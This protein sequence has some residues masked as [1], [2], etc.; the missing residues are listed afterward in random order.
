MNK[1]ECIEEIRKII[2]LHGTTTI[3]SKK[4]LFENGYDKLY[5][6][7][8]NIKNLKFKIITDTIGLNKIHN[9]HFSKNV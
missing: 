2:D 6:R 5:N 4:W 8:K 9:K 7:I 1:D 3:L